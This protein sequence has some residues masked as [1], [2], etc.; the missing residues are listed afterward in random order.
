[1]FFTFH[2]CL[3]LLPQG[4][5]SLWCF[6][7]QMATVIGALAIWPVGRQSAAKSYSES[8]LSRPFLVLTFLAWYPNIQ[9]L[10]RRLACGWVWRELWFQEAGSQD[11]KATKDKDRFLRYFTALQLVFDPTGFYQG[12]IFSWGMKG[13]STDLLAPMPYTSGFLM[14]KYM[15]GFPRGE[16]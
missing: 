9:R 7:P 10:K 5:S 8:L 6:V 4:K 16:R 3:I 14:A 12:E 13:V 1:M 11:G 2:Q 15:S